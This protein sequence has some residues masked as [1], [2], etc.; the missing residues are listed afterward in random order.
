MLEIH[1][2]QKSFGDLHVLRGIDLNIQKGDV[3]AVLG[4]SGSGKTTLLRCM[5][6]LEHADAGTMVFDG[7]QVELSR[8]THAQIHALRRRTGFVFQNY[9]LFANKTA[10]QNVTEGLVIARKMDKHQADEIARDEQ[11]K[12]GKGDRCDH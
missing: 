10:L 7:Q 4:S 3:V 12:V 11:D 1:D 9:N 5:N 8:I 6:F 2:L